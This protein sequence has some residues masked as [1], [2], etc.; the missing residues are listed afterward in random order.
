VE[1]DAE[2]HL[3]R[4]AAETADVIDDDTIDDGGFGCA[5]VLV[6]EV[7]LCHKDYRIIQ[8]VLLSTIIYVYIC[9]T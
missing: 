3:T 6:N 4:F 2:K 5:E 7:V 1:V 9:V 8:S